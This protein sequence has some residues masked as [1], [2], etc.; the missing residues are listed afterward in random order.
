MT[1]AFLSEILE[2]NRFH[3][4]DRV[5]PKSAY[6]EIK[7]QAVN[8]KQ[9]RRMITVRTPRS[10]PAVKP[11]ELFEEFEKLN[12]FDY[13]AYVTIS[14]LSMVE[15][16]RRYNQRGDY[17]NRI[18]ELKYDFGMDGFALLEFGA[19]EAAFT[20]VMVAY[21]IMTLFKQAIMNSERNHRLPT[22]CFQ[23]IAMGRYL[24]KRGCNPVLKLSAEGKRRRFLEHLFNKLE[25]IR[26]PCRFTNE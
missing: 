20:F 16:H 18:K 14:N 21:N 26:P 8:W 4:D 10:N 5:A 15:V 2:I 25:I 22:I 24:T 1:S 13:T 7:Y 19:M 17:E 23:C 12:K 9:S 6:A 3:H 11:K